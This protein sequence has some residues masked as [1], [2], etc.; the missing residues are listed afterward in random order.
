[1]ATWHPATG[2]YGKTVI[3]NLCTQCAELIIGLKVLLDHALF[4]SLS[5]IMTGEVLDR[6]V[7]VAVEK[8]QNILLLYV[9]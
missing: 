8:V 5:Q 1:M 9:T 2:A 7:V 6:V 3:L 4:L